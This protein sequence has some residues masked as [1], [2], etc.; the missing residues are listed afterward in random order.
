MSKKTVLITG[1]SSGFGKLTAK[2]FHE[3]GWNVIATMRAPEKEKEL[4]DT[5]GMLVTRLDV[6]DVDSI[7]TAVAEGLDTFG[8]IDALVNNAGYGGHAFLEQYTDS[9]IQAM[10]DTNVFGVIKVSREVLPLMRKQRSGSII[11]VT[12]M[13]GHVGI[14]LTS[15]YSATKYAVQGLSEAMSIEYKPFNISV[16]TVAPGAYGT[17]FTAATDNNLETGDDEI[18]ENAQKI[19][20]HFAGL[21]E[22]MLHQGGKEADPQEVADIIYRCVTEDT[23][24]HNI[25]G[26]DSEMI[27]NMKNSMPHEEFLAQVSAMV[28]PK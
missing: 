28:L 3:E 17:N 7:K 12:S 24:T 20:A 18:R 13:V 1:C 25:V 19:A 10:F 9:Q 15:V 14:A 11:N 27:M 4:T 23:P 16:K 6:T 2:K 22:Q 21:V 5:D 8:S 26:A